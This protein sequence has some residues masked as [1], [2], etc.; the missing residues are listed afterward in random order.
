M[1]YRRMTKF[2]GSPRCEAGVIRILRQDAFSML[3]AAEHG[4]V[5]KRVP[6]CKCSGG[7]VGE[8]GIFD[9]SRAHAHKLSHKKTYM[10]R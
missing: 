10:H 4:I 5:R 7:F 3:N 8:S 1:E 9:V 2:D 6:V